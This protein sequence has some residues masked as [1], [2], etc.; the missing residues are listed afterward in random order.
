[1]KRPLVEIRFSKATVAQI[2]ATDRALRAIVGPATPS[3]KPIKPLRIRGPKL[4][5][6]ALDEIAEFD[7]AYLA[8]RKASGG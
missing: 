7:A 5:F 6:V 4:S 1:V 8:T 3:L 2:A